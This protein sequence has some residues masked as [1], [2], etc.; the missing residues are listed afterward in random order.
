M[1]E[2]LEVNFFFFP[3]CSEIFLKGAYTEV[4][5]RHLLSVLRTKAVQL[6]NLKISPFITWGH[7][8]R[9]F[10]LEG[11]ITKWTTF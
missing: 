4:H 2:T 7:R 6:W 1:Y 3:K 11:G 8:G 9:R 10:M 5:T